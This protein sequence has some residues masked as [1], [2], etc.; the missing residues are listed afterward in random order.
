VEK[1]N[2]VLPGIELG[3]S[4]HATENYTLKWVTKFHTTGREWNIIRRSQNSMV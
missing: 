4:T 1:R 2:V 3:P